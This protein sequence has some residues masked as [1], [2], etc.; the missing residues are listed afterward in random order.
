MKNGMVYFVGA[1]PGDPELL[2]IKGKRVLQTADVVIFDRLVNPI[3]LTEVRDGAKLVYCGKQPCQHFL[4]QEDIQKEL[5]IHA[6]KGKKVV[7]LKGGDPAVFGRV[8][9]EA[10]LLS[11]NHI[12]YEI[13][14]GITSGI[15]APLYAGVTV[16]HREHSRS[17]A[18]V[19]GH[20]KDGEPEANWESLAKSVDTV[21]F[22]MG[23]RYLRMITDKLIKTGKDKHTAVLVIQWGTFS[24]QRTVEG[25]LATIANQIEQEGIKNPAIIIVGNVIKLRK[26]LQWFDNRLFSGKGILFPSKNNGNKEL[27]ELLRHKGAD[28]YLHPSTVESTLIENDNYLAKLNHIQMYKKMLFLSKESVKEFIKGLVHYGFDL[29]MVQ[30]TFYAA[31]DEVIEALQ[32]FG[33]QAILSTELGKW[34]K[35]LIVGG[36]NEYEEY[37]F[38]SQPFLL[39]HTQVV[40]SNEVEAFTRLV[41]EGHVN[42]LILTSKIE[43]SCF[44]KVLDASKL[45]WED[46]SKLQV[47]CKGYETA[48]ALGEVG[49]NV[50]MLETDQQLLDSLVNCIRFVQ[51]SS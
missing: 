49:L 13:I 48:S 44:I 35:V 22:Y 34:E 26:K 9:E 5:V 11:E 45:N 24:K 36:E 25:T 32:L 41:E 29:R 28:V 19:S 33:C 31:N 47:I 4:R 20:G 42:T 3:L 23:V 51:E 10:E 40:P 1:G 27:I 38:E 6:R 12:D 8:G 21:V 37:S 2:T 46:L 15:A 16:T 14:P 7:R 30:A 39:T 50:T 18:V 43:V 17:F